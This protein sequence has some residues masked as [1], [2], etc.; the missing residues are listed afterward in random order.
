M[1][2]APLALQLPPETLFQIIAPLCGEYIDGLDP[3]ALF[4][5][6]PFQGDVE[7]EHF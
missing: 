6:G 4:D 7:P 3:P 2:M 5:F 1:I